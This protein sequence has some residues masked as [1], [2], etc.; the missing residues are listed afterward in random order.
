MGF[1]SEIASQV[2]DECFRYL[3]AP[4]R[5]VGMKYVAAVPHEPGLEDAVLPQVDD[6]VKAAKD[7]LSF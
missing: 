6:V 4:V 1:G 5:R 2:A 3:D 7:L